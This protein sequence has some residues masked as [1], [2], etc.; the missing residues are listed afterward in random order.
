MLVA[1]RRHLTQAFAVLGL[2][3]SHFFAHPT[4]AASVLLALLLILLA[5]GLASVVDVGLHLVDVRFRLL[6]HLFG[7]MLFVHHLLIC[8]L[9]C[10]RLV[11]EHAPRLGLWRRPLLFREKRI[12]LVALDGPLFRDP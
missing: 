9:G 6:G 12:L 3:A 1:E 11:F 10:I 4:R 7:A 8:K 5:I 2:L